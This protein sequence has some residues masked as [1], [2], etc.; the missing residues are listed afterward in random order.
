MVDLRPYVGED[1]EIPS[2][3]SNSTQPREDDGDHP[4]K[5]L[6]TLHDD[7]LPAKGTKLIKEVQ[8]MVRNSLVH[9]DSELD[10]SFGN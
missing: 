9:S 7:P 2:L 6:E 10:H 1:Q 5:P 8:S 4:S 3:R